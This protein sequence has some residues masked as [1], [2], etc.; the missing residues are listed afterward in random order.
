MKSTEEQ[1]RWIKQLC[2]GEESAYKLFF[3]EYYQILG[4][5]AA[6][7]VQETALAEDIV[8]DVILDLYSHKRNFENIIA[9][10]SFLYLSIKNRSL[11]YLRHNQAKERYLNSCN[12]EESEGFFLDAIIEEEVYFLLKQAIVNLPEQTRRVYELSLKGFSNEEIAEQLSLSLDSI[13]SYKKRGK[14]MLKDK[15]QGLLYM[16]SVML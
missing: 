12:E 5:F 2:E 4:C 14:Q 7:Y 11:N 8:N 13:K 6:K 10:K 3:D 1:N 15:L 9:L 16:L